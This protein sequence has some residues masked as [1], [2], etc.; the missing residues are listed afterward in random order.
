MKFFQANFLRFLLSLLCALAAPVVNGIAYTLYAQTLSDAQNP[1]KR[2]TLSADSIAQPLRVWLTVEV[3]EKKAS[4]G[5]NSAAFNE[6]IPV[7]IMDSATQ[8]PLYALSGEVIEI[9]Q[10]RTYFVSVVSGQDK[11][12]QVQGAP[13]QIVRTS[14][15]KDDDIIYQREFIIAKEVPADTTAPVPDKIVTDTPQPSPQTAQQTAQPQTTTFTTVSA[16]VFAECPYVVQFCAMSVEKDAVNV[17]DALR[18]ASVK[19]VRIEL[20]NDTSREIRYHRVRAGC[21]STLPQAKTALDKFAQLSQQLKLG[22]VPIV[23]KKW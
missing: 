11:T 16:T 6:L 9:G 12:F 2:D 10:N 14:T 4:L 8:A 22:V 3:S 20:F 19:D 17:R 21:F 13:I 18:R 15:P 5:N 7:V 23:V 1:V